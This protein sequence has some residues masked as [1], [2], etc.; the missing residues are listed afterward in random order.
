MI[1]KKSPEEIAI[2]RR[3]GEIVAETHHALERA[4]RPGMTTAELDEIAE[5]V[6]RSAGAKPSFKGYRGYPASICTSPN[7]VIVHGIPGPQTL[8]DGDIVSIDIGA[9][10]EGFHAD[11]AWTYAVGE[12]DAGAQ[13]LLTATEQ[14]L[15]AAIAQCRPGNRLGDVGFAVQ[16]VAEGAGFSVVREYVGHGVG[17]ALHEEP[18]IPNYGPPG[19]RETL[20]PGM[21]LAIEPM[22]NAGRAETKALAD[23]W[24]VVTADGSLS[25]HFEHTVAI[26][27]DGR[28][29]LTARVPAHA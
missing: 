20:S 29:V 27:P 17:R 12:I 24:T 6:I 3:A 28:E 4:L 11:S 13:A 23:G 15:E 2:M 10:Y 16:E 19:R 14:S 26:T 21:T 7:H 5:E 22:V 18:Q 1:Y 9:L 8:D 25:A